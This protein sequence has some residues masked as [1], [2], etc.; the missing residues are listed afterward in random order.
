MSRLIIKKHISEIDYVAVGS[1]MYRNGKEY[2]VRAIWKFGVLGY[3]LFSLKRIYPPG[4][5]GPE[6][7]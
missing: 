3:Y 6:G 4:P 1:V 5:A 2:K 7:N